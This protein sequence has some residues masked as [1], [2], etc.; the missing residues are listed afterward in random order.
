MLKLNGLLTV[1]LITEV[2]RYTE[3]RF[4][5]SKLFITPE[6]LTLYEQKYLPK[7]KIKEICEEE[8]GE[9]LYEPTGTY[10][11]GYIV[12][13]FEGSGMVPVQFSPVK[14][15]V[16]CVKLAEKE[17]SK[18]EIHEHEYEV[19]NT[20]VYYYFEKY[21]ALYGSHPDLRRV[22]AKMLLDSIV[23]EGIFLEAADITIS[24]RG[25]SCIVYYNVR[26][27][28]VHSNRI[29]SENDMDDVLTC[30]TAQSPMN[31]DSAAPKYVGVDLTEQYRGR[32]CINKTFRGFAVTTRLLSKEAFTRDISELNLSPNTM[33]F[34]LREFM[35]REP[36]L[37]VISG[38]TMSGKNTTILT[39]INRLVALDRYKIVSIEQPVEQELL[40]IEQIE[41]KTEDEY[42]LAIQ[43]LIRQNPDFVYVTEMN[44]ATGADVIQITNTGKCMFTTCHANNAMDTL[45]RIVDMSGFPIERIIQTTHS[46]VYQELVRDDEKD[47]V[48]PYNRYIRL[49]KDRK[50]QLY[51]LSHGE[52]M[53]LLDEWEQGDKWD[54]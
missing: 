45:D 5:N 18:V 21:Q 11:P 19:V 12:R 34:L 52:M 32:V 9:K 46:I 22:P 17:V 29:L 27:R 2:Q 24:T 43:S 47:T 40:G 4:A 14:N 54:V 49:T 38:A 31:R 42:K 30:L 23:K 10:M 6:A 51:G 1:D 26:K 39:I 15:L 20:T 28:M 25:R 35:N 8:Y 37:R 53:K 3:T 16:T 36:G 7:E 13:K 44:D 33:E 41:A 50:M 48:R